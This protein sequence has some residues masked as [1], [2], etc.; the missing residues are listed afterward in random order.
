MNVTL[1]ANDKDSD[2]KQLLKEE[3]EV[4][5]TQ[6]KSHGLT[7][8]E[9][10]DAIHKA[11]YESQIETVEIFETIMDITMKVEAYNYFADIVRCLQNPK[12]KFRPSQETH[13]IIKDH[14][15]TILER[16]DVSTITNIRWCDIANNMT[17]DHLE[18]IIERKL[19]G[20]FQW[21]F[22][23]NRLFC[24]AINQEFLKEL[25]FD[26]EC[27]TRDNLDRI[28]NDPSLKQQLVT[29][30]PPE[31]WTYHVGED[32]NKYANL[33]KIE[34]LDLQLLKQLVDHRRTLA[35]GKLK[36]AVKK[37]DVVE[38]LDYIG[39]AIL[40][41]PTKYKPGEMRN[42]DP[43]DVRGPLENAY[44]AIG[45]RIIQGTLYDNSN[46]L[47]KF[48]EFTERAERYQ[49]ALPSSVNRM[50]TEQL[51]KCDLVNHE[52]FET[53]L[54]HAMFG[55]ELVN[56]HLGNIHQ[57]HIDRLI[58]VKEYIEANPDKRGFVCDCC[59]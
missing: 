48:L 45:E 15:T 30:I 9:L 20:I 18:I 32:V 26:P 56:I 22:R 2:K 1:I 43:D 51:F 42:Y 19:F 59:K 7:A 12:L 35:L 52:M 4:Y 46:N 55:M 47:D 37:E 23:V 29:K 58:R 10:M 50:I 8:E 14:I 28:I 38:L 44:N 53:L 27:F 11:W 25:Y 6:N 16:P 3:C 17:I 40:T 13:K 54:K 21:V 41:Y 5:H 24:F 39:A 49:I 36:D 57:K 31:K 34:K 33:G